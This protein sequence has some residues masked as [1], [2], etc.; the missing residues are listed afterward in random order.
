MKPNLRMIAMV[1]FGAMGISVGM[2]DIVGAKDLV[3][4]FQEGTKAYNRASYEDAIK[5]WEKGVNLA[6]KVAPPKVQG[7]FLGN[8]GA[9]YSNLCKYHEALSYYKQALV[10]DRMSGYLKGE[11]RDL[12]NIG[13]VYFDLGRYEKALEYHKQALAIEKEI[14]DLR[15]EGE[16]LANVADVYSVKGQYERALEYYE[17]AVDI[18][19]KT[20]NIPGQGS[21][22][23]NIGV[24]YGNLGQYEKA[25]QYYQKALSIHKKM[26]DLK[27][28]AGGIGNIGVVYWNL[29]Q[30][31]KALENHQKAL[32]IHRKIG[33][34]KGAA[35]S[36]HNIGLVYENMGKYKKSLDYYKK[37]LAVH[38]KIGDI[39]GQGS[40]FSSI[41][42][43]YSIIGQNE[44]ALENYQKA[45]TIHR[46]IGDVKG[47]AGSIHNIG[48]VY[49]NMGKDEKTL[50][51]YK[52]ALAV[53]RDIGALD[54]EGD[55]LLNMGSFYLNKG[56]DNR[57]LQHFKEA[58]AI[59]KEIG[60]IKS[61]G[62]G[63]SNIAIVY[64]AKGQNSAALKCYMQALSIFKEIGEVRGEWT[65]LNN[66]GRTMLSEGRPLQAQIHLESAAIVWES[67]RG[68]L[69]SEM[70]RTGF[71][72]TL[73]SVYGT[74]ATAHLAQGNHPGAFEAVERGRAKSFLDLLGTRAAGSR[75]SKKKTD[76]IA[77]MEWQLAGLR[78]RNLELSTTPVGK[79]T[80]SARK[81]LN[82]QISA[83]DKQRLE[84]VDQ[85]RRTDPELGSIIVVDP[86]SLKEIQSLLPSDTA[87]VEYFHPGKH[88][89]SG[90][91]QNKLWIF[92]VHDKGLHFKAVDV[93]KADLEKALEEY[94]KLAADGSSNPKAVASAGAKLHKWLIEPVEPISQL[95]NANTLVIVPWGPMFKIPFAA[96]ASKGSKPLGT[97]KNVVMA[98][99]AGVYRYL[100]KKRSS[101]RNNILSIGNPKTAMAPL[102][103]AEKEAREIAGLFDK[104][105]I[106]TRSK[107]TEGLIKKDYAK[108]G[109]PNVVH[110]ACHGIFNERAPQL[111]YLALTPDQK[112]DGKLEMHEL[113]DLDWR[114]VSLVTM[115][116]CS[117]GKG[118]L[119]AGDDLV[120]LTRGFMFAGA[121]S[122]LCS[123]WDVD[124][125][126]TRTLMVSFYKNYLSGMSKPEALRKAQ[127]AMMNNKKWSHPY[128]WSAF[129]LF[130]DWE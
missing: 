69:E 39:R 97:N 47:A 115:S 70:D 31:E 52:R 13:S 120:G 55:I 130:G 17:M 11:G 28:E 3:Q 113:F 118:K 53:C 108:L 10:M 76:Y 60:D 107:A 104:S 61:Q 23:G 21:T 29:G 83:L 101:G 111:S 36:I 103:G 9:A 82:Q 5:A 122:I 73:S 16:S 44:K 71:Q 38:K 75:R 24:V 37:S 77:K 109:R 99:S 85:L 116:A 22:L 93:S 78:E 33:D 114:G 12:T 128:Y 43:V 57:A 67:I 86:P 34:V 26:G 94:A 89:V 25:L 46:K 87:L 106:Y 92:A 32:T 96:L 62:G 35:G 129:V 84:L 42:T 66:I 102:P 1:L 64:S 121:P 117:S 45:L 98:P 49:K 20:G 90:K 127:M 4:Y 6:K 8:I 81:A 56:D 79:K 100:V 88:T 63:L 58:L 68:Q 18:Q 91:K 110:L 2:T 65:V 40:D 125:E 72:S 14:G 15:G 7:M 124:D 123:L 30:Y 112:N 27:G 48:L 95:I 105:A 50:E 41:A 80:R 59:H 126:A 51:Y 19:K 119:G 54:G 74:L